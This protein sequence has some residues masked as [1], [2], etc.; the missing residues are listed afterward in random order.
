MRNSKIVMTTMF[1]NEASVIRRMLDSCTQYVDFWVIQN[2]G[3]TDETPEV[4]KQWAE[5]TG[6]PGVLYDV[7]EGWV[8]F[9]WNR[10]HLT[11]TCQSID[12]GCDWI[13]KMDCDEVLEVDADMDWTP[14][15]NHNTHAFNISAVSGN[16]IYYRTW[17]WNARLP[18][19]FNHD[20]C[21]ET[22][23][24]L[25]PEI[26]K[27]YIA[28]D[29]PPKIRQVG[30]NEG[31][32]WSVATKFV[33]D[34]LILEEKMIREKLIPDNMYHFW[35][36]GK[37]YFDAYPCSE[38]P[39]GDSQQKEFARRCV[40]YFKE[41]INEVLRQRNGMVQIDEMT[42]MSYIFTGSTNEFLGQYDVAIEMY[43]AAEGYAPGRNDHLFQLALLYE[44]RKQ[45]KEM[46]DVTTIMM[47]SERTNPFPAYSMFI[48][49]SMYVDS[50]HKKVQQLH[51]IALNN[52]SINFQMNKNTRKR[53]F[54]V[55]DFYSNPDEIR[56]FALTQVEFKEDNNWYK[57]KR[58][59]PYI[60]PG[61][62]E[63][64][65]QIMGQKI[66]EF[67]SHSMNGV[68]QITTSSDRQVYHYDQQAWA[69]MIYL[70]PNAPAQSGTRLHQSKINGSRDSRQF[71]IDDA[72]NGDFYDSTKFETV[73][74][75]GNIYNRLV[76]M[77][78]KCIHSAG[79]YFGDSDD[80]GRLIHLFFFD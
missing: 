35:Y 36:I 39:L 20:P 9:G 51:E 21:H 73:D 23:Y 16:C 71:G 46:L 62:K 40:Y 43:K 1:K 13:L 68:F 30:Y 12:H 60:P 4:V 57:G 41:Y 70:T 15:D 10:D 48:D 25:I 45:Y 11:R 54:I 7:E 69:A 27:N 18:W 72:F 74:S 42:Y 22:I 2:N 66:I 33:S 6:I 17:M 64:F 31:Q 65:E 80:T 53:I 47:Q 77:D 76:I 50:Q 59:S 19:A 79:N 24:C 49:T 58:S 52:Q 63:R 56:E 8:G 44:K 61:I 67:D 3:S 5:E 28:R 29:L 32:S 55:D 14:L 37:S 75:A 38:F 26:D 78:A 34:S